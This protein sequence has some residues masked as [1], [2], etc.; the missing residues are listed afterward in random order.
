[1]LE[2]KDSVS[3]QPQ[4]LLLSLKFEKPCFQMREEVLALGFG[5]TEFFRVRL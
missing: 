1:M 2:T 5:E 3:K 4:K